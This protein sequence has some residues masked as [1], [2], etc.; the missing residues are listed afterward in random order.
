V[1]ISLLTVNILKLTSKMEELPDASSASSMIAIK[2]EG[3]RP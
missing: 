1:L 2:N 3:S